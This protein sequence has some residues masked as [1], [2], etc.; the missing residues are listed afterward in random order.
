[1][2]RNRSLRKTAAAVALCCVASCQSTPERV[3]DRAALIARGQTLFFTETF[4]GNGRTCGTCHRRED[5]YTLSPDLIATLAADDPLF[6][7]ERQRALSSNFEKPAQMHEFGLILENQDGFDDLANNFN[8][9]GVPHLLS[10]TTSVS[11]SDGPHTGWSGDGAPGD[12][13]VRAFAVGAVIE[14]FPRTL[15]RVPGKDYRLPTSEELDALAAFVLSLGRQHDL[16]LPLGL[17]DSQALLGQR[18]F[19]DDG[20]GGKCNICH[21]NAGANVDEEFFWRGAG[22][23]NFDTGLPPLPGSPPDDGFGTPGNHEFNTPPLVEAAD[24]APYFHNN[25]AP[26][27]EAAITFY[28]T[29]A[30]NESPAGRQLAAL[31]GSRIQLSGSEILAVAAFLRVINAL[32]NIRTTLLLL[33]EA[34][35]RANQRMTDWRG[36]L[37]QARFETDDAIEVLQASRLHARAIEH[38]T[39]ARALIVAGLSGSRRGAVLD[40]IRDAIAEQGQARAELVT[41]RAL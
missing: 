6:V 41:E 5:N 27:L 33:Q 3:D 35:A 34:Q 28:N 16:E 30:F 26:T 15:A 13:S 25:S 21:F 12:G 11:S 4:D 17:K 19:L 10:L 7:A 38:L 2:Y 32:E 31:T 9:R 40:N 14:H 23:L 18:V 8:L 1:V 22:N 20:R 39:Q 29:A 36:P 24:T 37:E